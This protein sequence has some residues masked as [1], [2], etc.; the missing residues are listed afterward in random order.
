MKL[1]CA[2]GSHLC[3]KS[4]LP[5]SFMSTPEHFPENSLD[6]LTEQV[7]PPHAMFVFVPW[8]AMATLHRMQLGMMLVV[9]SLGKGTCGLSLA[10]WHLCKREH[11]GAAHL[12]KGDWLLPELG[13]I[14]PS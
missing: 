9:S 13:E 1:Y 11:M 8:I 6:A 2:V 14:P 3:L 7:R 12:W 5:V 10:Q 4:L